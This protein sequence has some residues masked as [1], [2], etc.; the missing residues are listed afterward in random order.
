MGLQHVE[1]DPRV[2]FF[3]DISGIPVERINRFLEA[4][5]FPPY[6]GSFPDSHNGQEAEVVRKTHAVLTQAGIAESSPI[7]P[8][9]SAEERIRQI[10]ANPALLARQDGVGRPILVIDRNPL[11]LAEGA[12]HLPDSSQLSNLL[13]H[14]MIINPGP[15]EPF[16]YVDPTTGVRVITLPPYCYPTHPTLAS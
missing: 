12:S 1:K 11:A 9:D 4:T 16:D 5:H 6:A 8:C 3:G 7:I 2:I 10:L 14:T 15:G 13:N